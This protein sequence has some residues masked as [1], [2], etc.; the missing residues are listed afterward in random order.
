MLLGVAEGVAE[1][2]GVIDEEG[3]ADQDGEGVGV[4]DGE[5]EREGD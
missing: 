4:L 5:K 1:E 2:E 3:E